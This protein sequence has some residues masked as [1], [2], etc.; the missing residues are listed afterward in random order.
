MVNRATIILD[1]DVLEFLKA[2]AN[3]NRSAYINRIL[4]EESQRSLNQDLLKANLEEAADLDYQAD[5]IHW[6]NTLL[7]GLAS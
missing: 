4:R 7:D 3:P 1:D 2:K 5:L 6:D